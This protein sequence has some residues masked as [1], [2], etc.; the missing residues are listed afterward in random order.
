VGYGT[1]IE[2]FVDFHNTPSRKSGILYC[3]GF[4]LD[5]KLY[6]SDVKSKADVLDEREKQ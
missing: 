1:G 6:W 4:N 5:V 3:G 2:G